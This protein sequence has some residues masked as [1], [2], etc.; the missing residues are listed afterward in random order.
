VVR[1][2]LDPQG[3]QVGQVLIAVAFDDNDAA[4]RERLQTILEGKVI[5][6]LVTRLR[7]TDGEPATPDEGDGVGPSDAAGAST[8]GGDSPEKR[9]AGTP[10]SEEF[11]VV[12]DP[13]E[14][15]RASYPCPVPAVIGDAPRIILGRDLSVQGMRVEP[16]PDLAL[17]STVRVALY[18]GEGEE[19]LTLDAAVSR[20][21][22]EGGLLLR[23]TDLGPEASD[24]LEVLVTRLPPLE[25]LVKTRADNRGLFL[26]T[27][28][29]LD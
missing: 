10:S 27:I 20:D 29:P 8:A 4:T 1:V 18:G 5:G 6:S 22:G 24:R 12:I 28:V 2:K 19:P 23:F 21:D 11:E 13:R 14:R 26:S 16:H 9:E 17:G 3:K 25:A 15:V 7:D